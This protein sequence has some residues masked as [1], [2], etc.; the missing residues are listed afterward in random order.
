MSSLLGVDSREVRVPVPSLAALVRAVATAAVAEDASEALRA[1]A[2]AAQTVTSADVALVRAP[3]GQNAVAGARFQEIR[4]AAA[5]AGVLCADA[6]ELLVP[7][8][9]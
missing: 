3:E 1:L 5:Q 8:P 9:G 2:E 4:L 6:N 7:A